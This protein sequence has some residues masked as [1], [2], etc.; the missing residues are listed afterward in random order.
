MCFQVVR[1]MCIPPVS[2]VCKKERK[3]PKK[4]SIVHC[5]NHLLCSHILKSDD[6]LGYL[7]F[8]TRGTT[9]TT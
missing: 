2:P 5:N 4:K 6:S 8:R 9:Q 7:L 3:L 1:G